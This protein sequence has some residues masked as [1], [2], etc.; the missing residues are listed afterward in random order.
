[1]SDD[2]LTGLDSSFLHLEQGPAHMHVASTTIFEGPPP[3]YDEL[4]QHIGSRLHLVPRFRQKLAFVPLGQGRPKWVDD[5]QF[6]IRYHVRHTALPPPGSEGQLRTLAA[7]VFSQRLDRSKPLWETWMVEGLEDNRF[8]LVTKSHHCLVDGVSG[9]D[10]TTVLFDASPDPEP[11]PDPPAWVA[12]PV[13]SKA[14]LV[15]EAWVERATTPAEVVRGARALFRAPRQVA[16]AA[17]DALEAAGAFAKTGLGAPESPFNVDIGPYRRFATVRADLDE[18][19]RIKNAVGGTV[20]DVVLAVVAGAI[21]RWLSTHHEHMETMRVQVPVSMHHR[22]EDGDALGNRDSFLFCD[23]PISEPDPR[24]RLAAINAETRSR[25]EHHDPA[26][27]YSFFHSLSHI[28]PLYRAASGFASG[29][30]E[31]ALSV[32]NVPGPREPISLLGGRVAELY[33]AAEPADRHALR[34]S[35]ISLAG[36]M[37]LGFCTDPGAVPGVADLAEGLDESLA[38]LLELC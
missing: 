23:L 22:E 5:P 11:L 18:L 16:R 21:R 2:R 38:E 35:A 20:N 30:R 26:E 32:S 12:D 31:F 34:A 27:L 29:P 37:G 8:A 4:V 3:E 28:R 9:I 17:V 7:R 25:K 36:R 10:I 24:T 14:E 1:M 6:N 33:S 13:P 15:G 19:K